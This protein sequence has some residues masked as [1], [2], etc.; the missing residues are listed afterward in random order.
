MKHKRLVLICTQP[1]P[2]ASRLCSE[3]C[4]NSPA[5]VLL[6]DCV[7]V[8]LPAILFLISPCIPLCTCTA[9]S[10]C[11]SEFSAPSSHTN[12]LLFS[13]FRC[14]CV[15][16]RRHALLWCFLC[17]RWEMWFQ[18]V[19]WPWRNT[20]SL[21]RVSV[22][23]SFWIHCS[24]RESAAQHVQGWRPFG[25]FIYFWFY[26]SSL[27]PD[28]TCCSLCC[29]GLSEREFY[30]QQAWEKKE[31]KESKTIL[32]DLMMNLKA[33]LKLKTCRLCS[34]SSV[35]LNETQSAPLYTNAPRRFIFCLSFFLFFF[36]SFL[37]VRFP[38]SYSGGKMIFLS[39]Q[40]GKSSR[41]SVCCKTAAAFKINK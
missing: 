25:G 18:L 28:V 1:R 33:E 38:C 30:S 4:L 19:L 31:N 32:W 26:C 12:L 36:L 34:P 10:R 16:Q 8:L 39:Q 11:H 5:V 2:A 22:L 15:V 29:S 13:L 40:W 14:M 3:A 17:E 24:S 27:S 21:A 20:T 35:L 23:P 6:L 41:L 9:G 37:N 7:C